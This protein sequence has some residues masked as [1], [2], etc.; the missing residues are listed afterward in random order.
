M[1]LSSA[2]RSGSAEQASQ[3]PG[4]TE[5]HRVAPSIGQQAP[6]KSARLAHTA[7]FA[8]DTTQAKT[9]TVA[10]VVGFKKRHNSHQERRAIAFE[11]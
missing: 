9:S 3:A 6:R 2:R 7:T 11:A 1:R 5:D 8:D 10:P 4:Q